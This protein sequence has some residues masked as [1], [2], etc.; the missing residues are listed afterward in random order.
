L[1]S[2]QCASILSVD[3]FYKNSTPDTLPL[4]YAQI[5][6]GNDDTGNPTT[7]S[8]AQNVSYSVNNTQTSQLSWKSTATEVN[9]SDISSGLSLLGFFGITASNPES[10]TATTIYSSL[11]STKNTTTT[12][13]SDL[14]KASMTVADASG[15]P[16]PLR[17]VW[18]TTFEGVAAQDTNLN[19]T[20]TPAQLAPSAA[21]GPVTLAVPDQ[22]KNV[23]IVAMG[24]S[25]AALRK[26]GVEPPAYAIQT[27]NNAYVLVARTNNPAD[28]DPSE[29][30]FP[31]P[32]NKAAGESLV[33]ALSPQEAVDQLN[34]LGPAGGPVPYATQHFRQMTGNPAQ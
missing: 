18:D 12:T 9:G 14:I 8:N 7:F 13:W 1:S 34:R 21:P 16:I 29:R 17:V 27:D 6:S 31:S 32:S 26:N 22:L 19:L 23:P 15:L 11:L 2:A 5:F 4:T 28:P 20:C 3:N 24:S 33:R 25:V 30:H 10:N